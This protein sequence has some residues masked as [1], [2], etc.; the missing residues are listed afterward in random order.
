[1][2]VAAEEDAAGSAGRFFPPLPATISA[3][4]FRRRSASVP[5][6]LEATRL[7][8]S[9]LSRCSGAGIA[10]SALASSPGTESS[11][12]RWPVEE[13]HSTPRPFS[14]LAQ[15][16]P[17]LLCQVRACLTHVFSLSCTA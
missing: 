4:A 8:A 16:G 3:M 1:M 13:T 14:S 2:G 7:D 6:T 12:S 9:V 11:L 5:P 10:S 15:L 17:A